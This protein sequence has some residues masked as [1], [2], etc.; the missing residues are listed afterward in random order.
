MERRAGRPATAC[1]SGHTI[2]QEPRFDYNEDPVGW[3]Y[4]NQ[5]QAEENFKTK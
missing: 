5:I 3:F 4:K 2:P 1:L